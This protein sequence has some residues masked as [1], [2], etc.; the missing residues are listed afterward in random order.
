MSEFEN[1]NQNFGNFDNYEPLPTYNEPQ[2]EPM[3]PEYHAPV[4]TQ[5]EHKNK[6]HSQRPRIVC[7]KELK[8]VIIKHGKNHYAYY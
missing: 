7:K 4:M 6:K 3:M 8:K 2:E 5:K 1:N